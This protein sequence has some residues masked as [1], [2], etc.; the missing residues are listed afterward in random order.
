MIAFVFIGDFAP[1]LTAR[2]T[3]RIRL[4]AFLRTTL[5]TDEFLYARI[6]KHPPEAAHQRR[7]SGLHLKPAVHIGLRYN[8]RLAAEVFHDNRRRPISHHA[9]PS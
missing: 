7:V 6:S 2:N 1:F 5:K 3:R 9:S 8:A 4:F